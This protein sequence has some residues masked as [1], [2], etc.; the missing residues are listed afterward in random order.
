MKKKISKILGVV[1]SLALLSSLAIVSV[2]VAA[3]P[4][5]NVFDD[6]GGPPIVTPS[7]VG[8]MAVAPDGTIYAS[9]LNAYG[10]GLWSVWKSVDEGTNWTP[11]A[12]TGFVTEITDIAVS[13]NYGADGIFYISLLNARIYRMGDEGAANPVLLKACVDS[14]GSTA[15]AVYDL[16]LWYDGSNIWIMAGTNVDVLVLRDAL[17]E[18]WRDQ[19]LMP[20]PTNCRAYEVAYAPDFNSSNII[21]AVVDY[22]LSGRFGITCTVSPGQWGNT[23]KDALLINQA[24]SPRLCHSVTVC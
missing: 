13:P 22:Q 19:E 11:T 23:I 24:P 20:P 21:W 8:V 5:Q 17:F 3:Q 15:N 2:P 9:I 7:G 18:S 10:L 1:L 14:D 16:D 4:G 6:I 12:F